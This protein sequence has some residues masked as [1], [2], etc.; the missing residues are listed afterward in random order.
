[1]EERIK[2][3][4]E[5]FAENLIKLAQFLRVFRRVVASRKGPYFWGYTMCHVD[6]I[7]GIRINEDAAVIRNGNDEFS[8]S[9][10][11]IY[12]DS[13]KRILE[14]MFEGKVKKRKLVKQI[15]FLFKRVMA[16]YEK[17]MQEL[18]D[19]M[20]IMPKSESEP[21]FDFEFVTE[22]EPEPKPESEHVDMN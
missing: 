8:I 19:D 1:M 12:Y 18:T 16:K 2:T 14:N 20:F 21:K 10:D 7:R 9:A 17:L 3:E 6:Q 11:Y 5:L 13:L 4:K 22:L 15:D